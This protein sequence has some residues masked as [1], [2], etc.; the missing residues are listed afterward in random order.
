MISEPGQVPI[1][2]P[3]GAT[4]EELYA[5]PTACAR[6]PSCGAGVSFAGPWRSRMEPIGQDLHRITV[7]ISNSSP[8]EDASREE[9]LRQTFC[10]AH[11]VLHVEDGELVSLTDP[12]DGS[13][14]RGGALREHRHLAGARRRG[15]RA[16]HRCSRRRSSCRTTRRSPRRAPATC[17]TRPRSTSSCGSASSAMTDEEKQEMRAAD[18]K[19][20]EILERTESLSPEEL[21]RLHGAIREMSLSIR[22]GRGRDELLGAAREAG[23]GRGAR[24]RRRDT[25]PQ[26]SA[27]PAAE[28][29][30]RL[31]HRAGRQDRD[32]R[33]DRREHGG[34]HAAR[35]HGRGR[36]RP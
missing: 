2:I 7:R 30:R 15:G 16:P 24:E 17:S 11:T 21:M 6:A 36:S 5:D 20:R 35:G 13:A 29:A 23:A 8:I 25:A 32:R 31:R 9:V 26:P 18:P 10:S 19:A 4:E 28:G 14:G 1:D 3:A 33:G 34:R 22:K 27:S 12:P